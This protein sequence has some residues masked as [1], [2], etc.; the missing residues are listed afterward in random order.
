MSDDG[1][2]LAVWLIVTPVLLVTIL[3]IGWFVHANYLAETAVFA[4]AEEA[5]RRSTFE[6]SKA[7][8]QGMAQE[9]RAMQQDYTM[10]DDA[11]KKALR[12]IIVH[13]TADLELSQLP[14][15]L[16]SFVAEMRGGVK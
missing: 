3:G 1:K 13:R 15:D 4:P 8:R 6:Q 2:E 12:S 9:I 5:V 7:Y 14:S 11:H 16:A 10:A